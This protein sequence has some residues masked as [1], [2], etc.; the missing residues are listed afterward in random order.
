MEDGYRINAFGFIGLLLYGLGIAGLAYTVG[1][2]E[3]FGDTKGLLG[4]VKGPL[5]AVILSFVTYAICRRNVTAANIA[6][7]IM[8]LIFGSIL[9]RSDRY[10]HVV[11]A[12]M[13]SSPDGGLDGSAL[14]RPSQGRV[15][16][17]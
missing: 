5:A 12:W 7:T 1:V 8:L 15:V 3:V 14:P 16:T 13:E 2:D 4:V 9:I 10:S 6:L 11:D 17:R